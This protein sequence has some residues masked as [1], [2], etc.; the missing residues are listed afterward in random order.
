METKFGIWAESRSSISLAC[1]QLIVYPS[2]RP[3]RRKCSACDFVARLAAIRGTPFVCGTH[4]CARV[5]SASERATL[6]VRWAQNISLCSC[7]RLTLSRAELAVLCRNFT[8]LCCA[9][10]ANL[11]HPLLIPALHLIYGP[12]PLLSA[13]RRLPVLHMHHDLALHAPHA[14]LPVLVL[15]FRRH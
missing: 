8:A 14:L 7:Q 15:G 5:F 4:L 1:V 11:L 13:R 9:R 3:E 12:L 6:T 2:L 10:C